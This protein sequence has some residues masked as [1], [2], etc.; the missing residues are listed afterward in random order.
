MNRP[1]SI[2]PVI[3]ASTLGILLLCGLG[4]W[5]LQRL[6]H[7]QALLAEIDRRAMAAPVDLAEA[8]KRQQ[9][10]E[11]IEFMKVSTRGRFLHDAE[12]HMIAAFEGNPAWEV[13]TPLVTAD[14]TLV[15]VDRGLVPDGQRDTAKRAEIAPTGDVEVSGLVLK[16]DGNRGFFSPDNDIKA[17]MWFWWDV[18]AMLANTSAPP[19]AKPAFFVLHVMPV[20]GRN[21]FPRPTVPR[22]ALPNNHL[23]Y[24]IT[25]FSLALVLAVIAG[26]F[27][28]GQMK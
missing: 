21:G 11:N 22:A 26:L 20:A 2:W 3:I 10:G 9:S 1:R 27:V 16:H 7:K 15:L 12:K 19:D 4:A 28:R 23:Q 18:P 6:A 13:V 24:A 14:N 5:Q 25:W 17:N 8:S